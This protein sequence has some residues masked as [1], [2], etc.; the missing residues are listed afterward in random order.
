M[1]KCTCKKVNVKTKYVLTFLILEEWNEAQQDFFEAFKNYDEAGSPQRIQCLKYLVLANLL[2]D[3]PVD[4]FDS[5]EAAPYKNDKE[6]VAMTNLV[7]A[8]GKK[9]IA[10]FERILKGISIS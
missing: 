10:K 1:G 6:I 2:T 9:E 3:N 5:Q 4:P 8:F 7:D